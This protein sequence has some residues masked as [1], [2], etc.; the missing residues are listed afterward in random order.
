MSNAQV[1]V[2]G[3]AKARS[4][5]VNIGWQVV[6]DH[7]CILQ[8]LILWIEAELWIRYIMYAQYCAYYYYHY[9]Y[10]QCH[11]LYYCSSQQPSCTAIIFLIL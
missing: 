1:L 10:Y 2:G 8:V 11:R 9:Y 7:L 3:P 5:S 6:C 4:K